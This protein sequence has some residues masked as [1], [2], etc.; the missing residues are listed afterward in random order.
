MER[1]LDFLA[2]LVIGKGEVISNDSHAPFRGDHCG[3]SKLVTADSRSF[4]DG[5]RRQEVLEVLVLEANGKA[6][7]GRAIAL[8]TDEVVPAAGKV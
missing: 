8:V 5:G 2:V 6:R 1:T 7:E 4:W 3:V